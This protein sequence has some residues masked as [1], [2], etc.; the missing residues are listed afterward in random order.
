MSLNSLSRRR[1]MQSASASAIMVAT[2]STRRRTFAAD[3]S[4]NVYQIGSRRELFV[5]EALIETRD[6]VDLAMHRPFQC[7][8]DRDS[9]R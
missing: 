6:D 7:V 8:C 3:Q 2:G 5:D 4:P 9:R 1:W